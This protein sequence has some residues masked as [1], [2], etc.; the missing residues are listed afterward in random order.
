M[1]LY[2][3]TRIDRTGYDDSA[4]YVIA[5]PRMSNARLIA[6]SEA[7]GR[8]DA[9]TWLNQATSDGELLATGSKRPAGIVLRDFRAG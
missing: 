8:A 2:L 6:A 1:N 9:E 3:I 7:S 5:A 4:G